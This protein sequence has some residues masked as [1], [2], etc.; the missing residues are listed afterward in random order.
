MP[1]SRIS[2]LT[3]ITDLDENADAQALLLLARS[4]SHNETIG[5][6]DFK[7][8]V[9]DSSV[10]ITGDQS[11][12]GAKTFTDNTIFEKNVEVQGDLSVK[13]D[14]F[15]LRFQDAGGIDQD[16][17]LTQLDSN[18][19]AKGGLTVDLDSELKGALSV[20]GA[21][22]LSSLD[23]SGASTLGSLDVSGASTLSSLDVSAAST[24]SS[25]DVSGLTNLNDNLT[26]TASEARFA[27]DNAI[28][29]K[30]VEIQGDLS[31][32]G[33]VFNLRFQ[34]AGG[35]DQDNF[36]TQLDSNLV[37][38]GGLTVDLDSELKGALSVAG[39]STLS[40]LDVSGASTLGSLDVSGASTLSSLDVSAAST[41]TSLDVSGNTV[42]SDTVI[43]GDLTLN[44]NTTFIYTNLEVTQDTTLN[45][46]SVTGLAQFDD[47]VGIGT[48]NPD[49]TLEV[50]GNFRAT[51]TTVDGGDSA[52]DLNV[53]G[54]ADHPKLSLYD[55][56][57]GN[58][59][60]LLYSRLQFTRDAEVFISAKS[61][62]KLVTN[63]LDHTFF[64]ADGNVGIGTTNP[65]QMLTIKGDK[66]GFSISSEDYE[67]IVYMGR[68]SSTEPDLGY[69]RLRNASTTTVAIDS[70]GDSYF[71]G[72]NVGIGTASPT[73]E[74][75]VVGDTNL[76]SL[77]VQSG[78]RFQDLV[79]I[80]QDIV[81][82]NI[83]NDFNI[84]TNSTTADLNL[85]AGNTQD[86]ITLNAQKSTNPSTGADSGQDILFNNSNV[87]INV[88][89]VDLS[90]TNQDK[91]K[92]HVSGD[93]KLEGRLFATD[94]F[95]TYPVIPK[96]GDTNQGSVV[97]EPAAVY[98]AGDKGTLI[99]TDNFIYI[100]IQD[101]DGSDV[102]KVAWKR[103]AISAW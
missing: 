31:V 93:V 40:S 45:T 78:S 84:Y 30:D 59:V 24:L 46:L 8:S 9:V 72:G 3:K 68:R 100:C 89:S 41:L 63:G 34:D 79:V 16:N 6:Q 98:S 90:P 25:L 2:D 26:V 81:G 83:G 85:G 101:S 60:N 80:D 28:F 29:E 17:F 74:L 12:A 87:G 96:V 35:I 48:T 86:L 15:N 97:A 50:A 76:G 42:L 103:M 70:A 94:V 69:F 56:N 18:L 102:S 36:L 22:T 47:K 21:S 66:S 55:K 4:K 64:S 88:A 44:G 58:E 77:L 73:S 54:G 38:K 91:F 43:N 1:N 61:D 53:G 51:K 20:A 7:G 67:N 57:G 10:L 11:V 23:V 75:Q 33:D 49:K 99:Y 95:E 52:L 27:V 19:V 65:G 82:G 14:V 5:Y 62:L 39:A 71:N 32:K 13:G 92:L 37:A